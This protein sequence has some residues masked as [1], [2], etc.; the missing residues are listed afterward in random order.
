LRNKAIAVNEIWGTEGAVPYS[1][2]TGVYMVGHLRDGEK[3]LKIL[4][5]IP[6]SVLKAAIISQQNRQNL[7]ILPLK[8]RIK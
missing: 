7:P 4:R 8:C 1:Q 6:I 5:K 3:I 2:K